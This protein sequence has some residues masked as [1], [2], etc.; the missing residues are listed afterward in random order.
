MFSGQVRGH[1]H[2]PRAA[3]ECGA[4]GDEAGPAA[5]THA[6]RPQPGP[7]VPARGRGNGGGYD[8]PMATKFSV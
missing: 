6:R 1:P 2:S 5:R 3:A 8:G 4:T 7:A